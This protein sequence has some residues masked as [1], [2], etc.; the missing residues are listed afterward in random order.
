[1]FFELH[2]LLIIFYGQRCIRAKY[3]CHLAMT[4]E[5]VDHTRSVMS[6]I[7]IHRVLEFL[8]PVLVGTVFFIIR[9][10]SKFEQ[11]FCYKTQHM[12]NFCY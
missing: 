2:I 5:Y 8:T 6:V 4:R 11:Y 3:C 1:M 10:K 12:S 7:S 9:K